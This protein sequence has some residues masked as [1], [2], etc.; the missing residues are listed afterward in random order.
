M[1]EKFESIT[2]PQNK[3]SLLLNT[4]L[5][6]NANTKSG[7]MHSTP[8]QYISVNSTNTRSTELLVRDL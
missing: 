7:G 2:D 1:N 6:T 4:G 8:A 5:S 3:S